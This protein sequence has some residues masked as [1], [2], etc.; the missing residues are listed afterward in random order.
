MNGGNDE[1]SHVTG[2][3]HYLV[4]L[5]LSGCTILV[6][7]RTIKM[8]C[9]EFWRE[10]MNVIYGQS[11]ADGKLVNIQITIEPPNLGSGVPMF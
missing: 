1:S 9:P 10:I 11:C 4:S 7:L 3:D 2:S 8:E 6:S 5:R